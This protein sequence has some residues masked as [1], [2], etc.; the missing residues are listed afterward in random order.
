[1]PMVTEPIE[2]QTLGRYQL[3][4]NVAQGGMARVW[5]ARLHGSRG[6]R[7][8]VAVKTILPGLEA[9]KLDRML[10][11]EANL[12]ATIHHPNVGTTFELGEQNGILYL[13]MEWIDGEGLHTV[14]QQSRGAGGMP[15]LAA[16]NIVGQACKGL[17][18][19]HEQTDDL[20][21][22]LGIVHRDV[23]PHNILVTYSGVAKLVDFGVAEATQRAQESSNAPELRGKLSY[24]APE[25]VCGQRPDRRAD[26]FSLGAVLY[27][28]TTGKHPFKAENVTDTLRKICDPRPV[29]PPSAFIADYPRKLEAVV[30]KALHKKVESRFATAREMLDALE[31][32]VPAAFDPQADTQLA[33]FMGRVLGDRG[34]QRRQRIADCINR[35]DL[36]H[37]IQNPDLPPEGTSQGSLRA[38]TLDSVDEAVADTIVPEERPALGPAGPPL[39]SAAGRRVIA[40]L[41]VAAVSAVVAFGLS[42]VG[43]SAAPSGAATAAHVK[44]RK[45]P[46]ETAV[47]PE[48]PQPSASATTAPSVLPPAPPEAVAPSP[49]PEPAPTVRKRAKVPVAPRLKARPP[50]STSDLKD[51]YASPE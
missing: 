25:V 36:S 10:L 13:V 32:A 7:K 24:V 5:V 6:F 34:V 23:S 29:M 43:G 11:E 38:I 50:R 21:T 22:P 35:I 31:E 1:M 41:S 15:L 44:E 12:A 26:I 42:L 30:T 33:E 27:L 17:H 2:G 9:E 48:P 51:P 16:V 45:T 37:A 28:A 4:M 3:L 47:V 49:R 18:A 8:L 46:G 39:R 14:L 20:G 40:A 19:A